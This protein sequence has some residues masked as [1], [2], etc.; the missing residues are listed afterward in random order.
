VS[1]TKSELQT[2]S[3]AAKE[4]V[5]F[6]LH[7]QIS[8]GIDSTGTRQLQWL[9]GWLCNGSD[10]GYS[11]QSIADVASQVFESRTRV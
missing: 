6:G 4:A 5:C 11:S 2:D 1:H 3:P 9:P 10:G 8:Q 7:R